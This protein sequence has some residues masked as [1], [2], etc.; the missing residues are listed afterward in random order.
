MNEKKPNPLSFQLDVS[1]FVPATQEEKESL[2]VMRES[3]S[4]WKDGIHR[5]SK[6]I[7]AMISLIVIVIV[8]IYNG[9]ST[10]IKTGLLSISTSRAENPF[11]AISS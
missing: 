3:R 2:V 6:N 4:F 8:L 9:Y 5:L 10:V 7:V 1:A 11:F